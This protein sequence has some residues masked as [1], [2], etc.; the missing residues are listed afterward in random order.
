MFHVDLNY[1]LL[2]VKEKERETRNEG[3]PTTGR[4]IP[5]VVAGSS[6]LICSFFRY[7]LCALSFLSI[8]PRSP[9][10]S[11][12]GK[13]WS[14]TSQSL[15]THASFCSRDGTYVLVYRQSQMEC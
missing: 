5:P 6:V 12:M 8:L 9:R 14:L 1:L 15:H 7:F 3:M 11:A 10:F 4:L 2:I 13:R